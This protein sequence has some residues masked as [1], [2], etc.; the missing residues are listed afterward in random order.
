MTIQF[1]FNELIAKTKKTINYFLKKV[2]RSKKLLKITLI[3]VYRGI[4]IIKPKIPNSNPKKI[5]TR[6][7]S[8]G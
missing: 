5:I 4:A 1:Q 3:V 7:T 6:K 8:R 2:F